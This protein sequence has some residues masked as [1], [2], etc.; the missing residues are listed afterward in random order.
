MSFIDRRSF[1]TCAAAALSPALGTLPRAAHAG[2]YPERS[3]RLVIPF[4]VGGATDVIGRSFAR[5]LGDRLGKPVAP[6]NRP[7]SGSLIG[8]DMVAKAAP[9]G[10][11]I[12]VASLDGLVLQPELRKSPPYDS[13]RDLR[14]ITGIASTPITFTTSPASGI[15]SMGELIERA[16]AQPGKIRYGSPGVGTSPHLAGQMLCKAASI[17]LT[18]VAY[19]GGAP[20]ISDLLGNHIELVAS[21][22]ADVVDKHQAGVCKVLALTAPRRHSSLPD[23]TTLVE[24]GYG[25]MVALHWFAL[26]APVGLPAPVGARLATEAKAALESA[27][28]SE[29]ATR[30]GFDLMRQS[31][32]DLNQFVDSE[33]RRW[34]EIIRATGA[35]LEG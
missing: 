3:L 15:R 21:V 16:R 8:T 20:A 34:S 29:Q 22:P 26:A 27:E 11:T 30:L 2:D 32:A 1:L 18:H 23:V 24:L 12:L 13:Q 5:V 7:G 33:R 6:D 4:A 17:S 31:G 14:V 9:D 25:D 35:T 28:L 19:R 10:Y